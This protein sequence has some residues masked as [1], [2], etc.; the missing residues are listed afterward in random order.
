MI[1][2]QEKII[3]IEVEKIIYV[4]RSIPEYQKRANKKYIESEKGRIQSRKN[5]KAYYERQK[6]K[7]LTEVNDV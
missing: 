1:Q 6:L 4:K 2:N 7:K 3:Y 5:Q